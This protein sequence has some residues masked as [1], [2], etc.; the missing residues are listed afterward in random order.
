MTFLVPILVCV[1]CVLFSYYLWK[2]SCP[3]TDN[4]PPKCPGGLPLLG[5]ALKFV[6]DSSRLWRVINDFGNKSYA[7]GGV[8]SASIGP[9]TIYAVTDP[10][11]V[12]A[13]TNAT[14]E[15]DGIYDFGKPWIGD[16]LIT[17]KPISWKNQRKLLNP[18]FSQT[19]MDSFMGVFNKQARKLVKDLETEVGKGPFDHWEYTKLNTLETTCLSALGVDFTDD[20]ILNSQYVTAAE[21]MFGTIVDRFRK[22]WLHSDYTFRWSNL[23][24]KQDACLKILHNMSNTVLKIRKTEF[25]SN[26]TLSD[27]TTGNTSGK[28]FKALMDLLL[29]LSVEK[30]V[31][32]DKEIR[33][34]VDT[35]IVGGYDTTA[36]VLM[37]T[38]LLVGSHP[39]AQEKVYQELKEVFGDS[40]RDVEKHDLSQLVYLEAVLKE[41]MRLY[42]IVPVMARR[43][44]RNLQL[45]N[46]T[47]AA[48]RSCFL[49]LFKI[50]RHPIWGADV[51]QF[52]PDRWLD[53]ATL[54]EN[55]NVFA[56]FGLGRRNCIGKTY[57][58]VSIKTTLAHVLRKY[59]FKGDHTQLE[60]KLDVMLKPASGYYVSIE[61]R[62]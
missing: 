54:P 22:F 36:A 28:K 33:E 48:G 3:D 5:H 16:G 12:F 61:K 57:A 18:A 40:D 45:K 10:D 19:V 37:F 20:T 4:E 9:R 32:N 62:N 44:D 53:P 55:P 50:L 17:A 24:K 30:G 21:E 27:R 41:S 56:T 14:L 23:K 59:R 6:G 13:I 29:E 52:N 35:M 31:M 39:E 8:I 1:A 47:L 42:P 43:L 51:D 25:N 60:L 58:Y 26:N 38:L 15:K 34:H 11:D 7:R 46:Y 2:K 49:F